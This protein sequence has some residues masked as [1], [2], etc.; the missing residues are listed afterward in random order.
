MSE[1][2]IDV[3]ESL[4]R[5]RAVRQRLEEQV[6]PLATSVDGR[7]FSY[8]S[9]LF[10]LGVQAGSYVALEQDSDR[11]LGQIVT[12][13]VAR[14]PTLELGSSEDG[15][16]AH[17]AQVVI[18]A[19]EGEGRVL[20][21]DG[22]PFHDATVRPATAGEVRDHLEETA[23]R[24][25]RL[26]IGELML[27]E[28]VPFSLDAGGFGRHTFLCGQS[29]SGKTYS[30]GVVLEQLL[31][32]TDL[33]I[34]VLDPNS[35]FARLGELRPDA[36]GADTAR[37]TE[38]TR[39]LSVRRAGDGLAVRLAELDPATQAAVLRLDPIADREEY[40]ELTALTDAGV[41]LSL[42][43][44]EQL[45]HDGGAG[46][47]LIG[48][49][50]NLGLARWS[51]W[52]GADGP[53]LV[54]ELARDDVR[55]LVVDLGSLATREE[56]ALASAAVLGELWRRREERRPVLI[57]IDEAHNVCPARP[58]DPLT[59]IAM[60][61]TV[62]IAGEGRKFGLYLLVSTQRPQKVHENVLSQ[63]DNL[64]LMRMNSLADLGFVGETFSF[65]PPSLLERATTFRQG[66]SL[67]AGPIAPHPAF[68]RF[69]RRLAQE[70]GGD[71]PADWSR[72]LS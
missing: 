65:V 36:A 21:G 35:D 26:E 59:A 52:A 57:V 66:E 14:R 44:L 1:A 55:C 16:V 28:G 51:I 15:E 10:G 62:R 2:P 30:L 68:L 43:R 53:S 20:S 46:R 24:R 29:G 61:H 31:L 6:L 18:R 49:A 72:P 17:R 45:E 54:P 50:R 37:Y 27:A 33:Q 11:R 38:A 3:Q 47:Q 42:E 64:L 58:D 48:R 71:V 70:G 56:Q 25:A 22:S 9:S 60:A 32:E 39:S 7:R 63:C 13:E 19:A 5:Y 40:A 4:A 69:G 67:A 41:G 8:Q 23:P 12:L 34:I